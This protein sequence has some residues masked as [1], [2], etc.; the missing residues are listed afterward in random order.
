MAN[1]TRPV[2]QIYEME[3]VREIAADW[4]TEATKVILHVWLVTLS[5]QLIIINVAISCNAM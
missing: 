1:P 3:I 2:V 4:L 5:L